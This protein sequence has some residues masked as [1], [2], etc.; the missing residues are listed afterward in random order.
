MTV[1]QRRQVPE[2]FGAQTDR[3]VP[4]A[5]LPTMG[6]GV[7]PVP[8]SPCGGDMGNGQQDVFAKSEKWLAPAPVPTM[9]QWKTREEEVAQWSS[10]LDDLTAWAAQASLEFSVEISHAS[11][12]PREISWSSLNAAQQARARRLLAII[13]SAF[14]ERHRVSAL[15]SAFCEGVS[16]TGNNYMPGIMAQPANG[17][18]LIRQLTL[19]FSIRSRSEALSLRANLSARSFVLSA[20]E[21]SP[22][23][24]VSDTIRKLDFEVAKFTKLLGTLPSHID[25]TGLKIGESDLL[26]MLLRS[27]PEQVKQFCLHHSLG[28]SYEAYRTAARRWEDQQRL[29]GDF[30]QALGGRHVQSMTYGAYHGPEEFDLST[31]DAF[32]DAVTEGKCAKCGSRKHGTQECVVDL[33][34]T[35][36][37]RCGN[38]GHVGM[39]CGQKATGKGKGKGKGKKGV[40]KSDHWTKPGKGKGKKGKLNEVTEDSSCWDWA[41]WSSGNWQS[42]QREDPL[43]YEESQEAVWHDS[44]WTDNDEQQEQWDSGHWQES[45]YVGTDPSSA[46][47]GSLILNPLLGMSEDDG[48]GDCCFE[49][50]FEETP[51]F[52]DGFS[53]VQSWSLSSDSEVV[54]AGKLFPL[55]L[56]PKP[57]SKFKPRFVSQNDVTPDVP[58]PFVHVPQLTSMRIRTYV[59]GLMHGPMNFSIEDLRSADLSSSLVASTPRRILMVDASRWFGAQDE[60]SVEHHLERQLPLVQPLLAQLSD[61]ADCSWWLLDSGASTSVLAETS[62]SAFG[63]LIMDELPAEQFRA[64]NGSQV[65]MSGSTEIAV[66]MYMIG[67]SGGK[68]QWKKARMKVLVG[69]IKHNILSISALAD[70]GWKFTQGPSGFD[71]YHT[72]LNLHCVDTAYFS[73]CPWVRLH[74]DFI[75]SSCLEKDQSYAGGEL[76]KTQASVSLCPLTKFD[77]D[78]AKHRRQ[79]HIPF[80]SRCL[81]CARGRSVFQR[82]RKRGAGR[83]VEVQADFAFLSQVGE[84][85]REEHAHAMKV[86]VLTEMMSGAIGYVIV[87]PNLDRTR[88]QIGTWLDHFGLVS[89]RTSITLHTDAELSVSELVGRSVGQY[90]FVVRR[91]A[92]QQHQAVGGAERAVRELKESLAVLRA[93]LNA[94]SVD[95]VFSEAG[96]TDVLTYCAL[97]HNHFA[98]TRGTDQTPLE[99]IAGKKLSKPVTTLY[100]ACVLAELPSSIKDKSPNETRNVEACFLHCGL[101]RGPLVQAFVRTDEGHELIRFTARNVRPIVPLS[102]K[103]QLGVDVLAPFDS[104]SGETA[105]VDRQVRAAQEHEGQDLSELPPEELQ[106]LKSQDLQTPQLL[107]RANARASSTR[108]HVLRLPE[109]VRKETKGTI[110]QEVETSIEEAKRGSKKVSF[111]DRTNNDGDARK[112]GPEFER[113]VKQKAQPPEEQFTPTQNCPACQ[114]GMDCPGIRHS[115]GCRRRF[116]AF[117]QERVARN[118]ETS[119]VPQAVDESGTTAEP[120]PQAG[121]ASQAGSQALEQRE[122]HPAVHTETPSADIYK[123]RFKRPAEVDTQELEREIRESAADCLSEALLFDWFWVETGEPV[124]LSS[125]YV[126]ESA[127]SFLPATGPDMFTGMLNAVRFDVGKKHHSV[128]MEL[129]G[130]TVLLWKPD[131]IVDDQTLQELNLDQG[132][133]GM[134]EELTNLQQCQTG[135]IAG[136]AEIKE[137]T[138]TH[139]NTRVINSRWVAAYKSAERVRTRIVAKDYNHGATAKSLGY[140]SPTPSIEAL[141][142]VLAISASRGFR[143]RSLDVGHAFMNS[144]ISSAQKIVLKMP[145]SVSLQSGE[146]SYLILSKALNGLRDAS[147]CW[148]QLL[149]STVE[150]AGLWADELEPCVYAGEITSGDGVALGFALAIVYVDDVLLASSTVEAEQHIVDIISAV[151]PTKTTGYVAESGS[152]TFIGRV[153][154]K[155]KGQNEFFLSVDP[156]YLDTTFEAFGITKGS[157][158]VPDIA[159]HLERTMHESQYQKPLSDEAYSRFRRALGRLLWLSQVRHDLKAWLSVIGTQQSKPMRGTEQAL[160]AVL[161]FLYDDVHPEQGRDT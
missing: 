14:K 87:G 10:Y 129:G 112:E 45:E 94:Q 17:Y 93:D 145:L 124:L 74:P 114:T 118:Q 100:G 154:S 68:P 3:G 108:D 142:L 58:Q 37:F 5:F 6:G 46:V 64:A 73:N 128:S 27:L 71:L 11:R 31:G 122:T 138:R 156:H 50:C 141:H 79:G 111:A 149:S 34:K 143:L 132:F 41:D 52:E 120:T 19:E 24:V 95:I 101:T 151:V 159:T 48:V 29:F 135:T 82:R 83:E 7:L 57:G 98:K 89:H 113:N 102:W 153:I 81:E 136:E 25:T 59:M 32:V 9:N 121:S 99:T 147:L 21:T 144:P 104:G 26:L 126:L 110:T 67:D 20:Q 88:R 96:L 22:S 161:R 8:Y 92:P 63:S 140:S 12:W 131:A 66:H 53:V 2:R 125:L 33:S 130:S 86:L 39:N 28:D 105:I 76:T 109:R 127:A 62:L 42:E 44:T 15:V 117:Q 49:F 1:Q 54:E 97:C 146:P 65:H 84:V 152:L 160:R 56:A 23:S 30:G 133:E 157:P 85:S 38:F 150:Q 40:I 91:A 69:N 77:E 35:K 60:I 158:N 16:L 61:M 148:L 13:R 80:D 70:S 18:E 155:E 134:K 139:P 78:L 72:Q 116:Q 4:D 43:W 51:G 137:L 36:C 119:T 90:T 75:V 103:L 47:V 55:S 107:P 115:A 106:R 123:A